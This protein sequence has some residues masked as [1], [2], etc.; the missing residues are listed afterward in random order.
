M[1]SY[2]YTDGHPSAGGL[3]RQLVGETGRHPS[4]GLVGETGR[5]PSAGLVGEGYIGDHMCT[6]N[7]PLSRPALV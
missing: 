5:H 2:Y 4:A 6:F 1:Q 7:V 3:D